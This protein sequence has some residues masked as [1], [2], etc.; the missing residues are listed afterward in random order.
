MNS[1]G[2][3]PVRRGQLITPFG[4][5]AMMV[6]YGGTGLL[7][8]GLDHWYERED[9]QGQ[10]DPQEYYLEEWRLQ[11]LLN[12]SHFRLP[13]DY[14]PR[15]PRNQTPNTELTVPF[16]R[17]PQW[18][19]CSF[20]KCGLLLEQ[21]LSVQGNVRC[22]E[23]EQK[24]KR[25][26]MYQVR[27]VAMCDRGHLQDFPWREWVHRSA[28]PICEKPLRLTATGSAS[29]AGQRVECDCGRSRTLAG[30]T[31]A[32]SATGRI[33]LTNRLEQGSFFACRGRRPWLGP[34]ADEPC[35]RPILGSLRT[36]ANVYY[37]QVRSAIYLP[38][39]QGVHLQALVELLDNPPISNLLN[40]LAGTGLEPTPAMLRG[41]HARLVQGYS[42]ADLAA[43]LQ[44]IKQSKPANAHRADAAV[45]DDDRETAFRR[46]EFDM[47]RTAR[48][49]SSL[50]IR[51]GD[52]AQYAPD[53]A[54]YFDR[55]MLVDKLRETRAL[56][57]FTRIYP[58]TDQPLERLKA[59]LWR[60]PRA[61]Q[62]SLLPAC[63]VYG[64]GI[65]LQ[66][67][68]ARMQTWETQPAVVERVAE[69][70][71]RYQ[72]IQVER[73]LK[74]IQITPRLVLLHTFAH[75][76]MN[77]LTFECGYSSAA[78]RER[79]YV[80][81]GPAAPMAG[82]L[83]YT[84]AGDAEGTMGGLVRMGKPGNLEPV[85]RRA[86]EGALWC[87]TDP[88]CME[89]SHRGGQGPDSL[90]LAAC[91][92]CALV[93]ETACERFNQFLDRGVVVGELGYPDLGYFRRD[94][95]A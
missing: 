56:V 26:Y 41:Q 92:N 27:F 43:G 79:L 77:R 37:P 35:D 75:L 62:E 81:A 4:T 68:E 46:A 67:D 14:R 21:P 73:Q 15:G 48:Q 86:L 10:V 63:T 13:P 34:D 44:I 60:T 58:E 17:F 8:A 51:A 52:L 18:Y 76:L 95:M 16:M 66:F 84:A 80:A 74:P 53:V 50:R 69:L 19:V 20:P 25:S 45:L 94:D 87:S 40:L 55:I 31:T 83:I 5:G 9:Q 2:S 33:H 82:I 7:T 91:H 12:V 22:P 49:D 72:A 64:E 89:M 3:G 88:V 47:L 85:I 78:L 57:G 29:L 28:N 6:V 24:K 54:A 93:P 42:D 38:R 61:P 11:E 36:A 70:A 32:D 39:V 30:I 23:C 65:F 59:M 71:R 1:A 90:N